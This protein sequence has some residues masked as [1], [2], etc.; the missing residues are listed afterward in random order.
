MDILTG[1]IIIGP[2]D[3]E[4]V[5]NQSNDITLPTDFKLFSYNNDS[6]ATFQYKFN[7]NIYYIIYKINTKNGLLLFFELVNNVELWDIKYM[8]PVYIHSSYKPYF[9]TKKNIHNTNKI[10]ETI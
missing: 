8:Q 9:E 7:N 6:T 5:M 1:F 4:N 10:Y 3:N 2:D